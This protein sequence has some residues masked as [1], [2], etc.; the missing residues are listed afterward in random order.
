M[1]RPIVIA[2]HLIFTAY[3][4]WLPNDPR[5]S[6]SRLIRSD[7]LQELGELHRGRRPVQPAGWEIRAFYREAAKRLRHKLLT[8]DE[9]DRQIIAAAFA[10]MIERERYTC[11]GCAILPDHIHLVI[12]KHKH[13]AEEMITN[14]QDESR[15]RLRAENRRPGSHP[16]WGGPGWK[17]FLEHPGD[18][19]R[20]IRYVEH[21][22]R[23]HGLPEQRYGFMRA[24]DGWPLQPG[25]SPHSPYA[26]RLKAAGRYP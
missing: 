5:G 10:V 8:F 6:S 21:N 12:R 18:V 14:L 17:V 20:T 7:P 11:W 19:Q 26:K 23:K 2:H 25:H 13:A 9:A 15:S 22:P 1:A 16:V 4:W 24:Y 3:G